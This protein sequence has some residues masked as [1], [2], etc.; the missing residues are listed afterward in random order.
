MPTIAKLS[1]SKISKENRYLNV[2]YRRSYMTFADQTISE[3]LGHVASD[4]VT[5]SGGA[6]AAVGGASGAALCEMVCIHTIE[7][8]IYDDMETELA[9]IRDELRSCR[10]RLLDLADEDSI[11]V[12]ELQAAFE[13]PEG[14]GRAEMIQEASIRAIEV[15]FEIAEAC[16]AIL[17][18]VTVVTKKGNQNALADAGTGAFLAYAALQASLFTVQSNL[19]LLENIPVGEMEKRSTELDRSAEKAVQQ[20]NENIEEQYNR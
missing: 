19:G 16:L 8:D 5:P 17:E 2:H 4:T 13:I 14:E 9:K 18:Y 15:P 3:F 6:V 12:D 10:V 1:E 20:V 11:A 7:I